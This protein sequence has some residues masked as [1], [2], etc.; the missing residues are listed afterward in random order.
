MF[1]PGD[2]TIIDFRQ[3]Y[4]PLRFGFQFSMDNNEHNKKQKEEYCSNKKSQ[5]PS[6]CKIC[7]ETNQKTDKKNASEVCQI[8]CLRLQR[9]AF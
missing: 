6:P 8:T 4:K 1:G 9:M 2:I 3:D 7:D 5:F